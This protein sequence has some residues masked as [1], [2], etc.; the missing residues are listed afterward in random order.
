MRSVAR[1]HTMCDP[2]QRISVRRRPTCFRRSCG[3]CAGGSCGRVSCGGGARLGAAR[4]RCARGPLVCWRCVR[5]RCVCSLGRVSGERVCGL[6]LSF[7]CGLGWV[8]RGRSAWVCPRFRSSCVSCGRPWCF[9]AGVAGG[10]AFCGVG[11]VGIGAM[12]EP[13]SSRARSQNQV[14]VEVSKGTKLIIQ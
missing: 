14:K 1:D 9:P 2:G 13:L 11:G 10:G 7:G 5:A 12:E 8:S 4:A 6:S 3:S